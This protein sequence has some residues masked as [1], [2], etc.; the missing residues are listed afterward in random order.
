MHRNNLKTL[1][2]VA[3]LLCRG[4]AYGQEQ[5]GEV[6]GTVVLEDGS[7]I[8]GASVEVSGT[9]LMKNRISVT[10]EDGIFRLPSLPPGNY[11]VT[12]SREGF[13]TVARSD[14]HV[15]LGRTKRLSI[16]LQ[17][18]DSQ[19]EI[20]ATGQIPIVEV[21]N[22]ATTVNVNR[23]TFTTIPQRRNFISVATQQAGVN[24][25]SEFDT[26][27]DD[28][29]GGTAISFDGASASEN[30][31]YIDGMNTTAME[32]GTSGIRVTTDFIEEVQVQSSGYA[33][34]YGG[35]LGGVI[36]VITRSGGNE[37]QGDLIMYYNSNR[38]S[39]GPRETLQFD[40]ED[41]TRA[42]YS[43]YSED[44]WN[45]FEP[46]VTV[47]GYILKDKL[48]FFSSF[49]PR[50]ETRT[51]EGEF[52]NSPEA[53]GEE[54]TAND[55]RYNGSAKI[56]ATLGGNLR[57]SMSGALNHR[58]MVNLLPN[59]DGTSY[60][61]NGNVETWDDWAWSQPGVTTST[62]LDTSMGNRGFLTVSGGY[63]RTNSYFS[64]ERESPSPRIAFQY[65]NFD[66]PGTAKELRRPGGWASTTHDSLLEDRYDIETR[67]TAKADLTYYAGY[68]GEHVLK[69]GFHWNHLGSDKFENASQTEYWRF[70][71]KQPDDG[72]NSYYTA[73]DGT[74][75]ETTYGYVREYGPQGTIAD[76]A[77]DRL[78]FYVQDAW[79]IS[80]KL[81][82]NAGARFERQDM[83]SPS[84]GQIGSAF[85]FGF[86]DTIAPRVGI[87][88]DL[89]GVGDTVI[90]GSFGRYYDDMKVAMAF[91][92]FGGFRSRSAFYDIAT[93]DWT[94]YAS[95]EGYL[96]TGSTGPVLGGRLFE[97]FD[98][99]PGSF[100]LVQ[101][102]QE[103]MGKTEFSIGFQ[104]TLTDDYALAVRFLHHRLVGTIEDMGVVIDGEERFY[105]ANPGSEFANSLYNQSAGQGHMPSGIVTPEPKRDYYSFQLNVDKKF[106][107]HWM[108]GATLTWS[109]LRGNFSGLASSDEHGRRDPMVEE[110]FD[111]WFLPYDSQGHLVYG[112]L[113]TDRPLK[114][115]LRGSTT[116]DNGLSLGTYVQATSGTPVSSELVLNGINGWYPQGRGSDGRTPFLWFIDLFAEYKIE[117]GSRNLNLNVNI[118]NLTNNKIAQ[119]IYNRMNLGSERVL[120]SEIFSG[121]DALAEGAH[122]DP[123]YKMEYE[124]IDAI[125]VRIGIKLTF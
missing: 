86:S 122:D 5:T 99:N 95:E 117:L 19:G 67:L 110:Y 20:V 43:N 21:R 66:V 80:E 59:P 13:K 14:I 74:V 48:W 16:I 35:S 107:K 29:D 78:S 41:P 8:P 58:K 34:E 22:G 27:G 6:I 15:E 109:R 37:F 77:S 42:V 44:S 121:F 56:T 112:P 119:R 60:Y 31:F 116:L 1:F 98:T 108:A 82:L 91:R 83:P 25:E 81:T 85:S 11:T 39:G 55:T 103:P 33:A 90:V 12:I 24:Y 101:P 73:G 115:K 114:L 75:Y 72:A 120:N 89:S 104:K 61:S 10:N 111:T 105:I 40:R 28:R 97:E 17:M 46:G 100:G 45:R 9:R 124:Y 23:E 47:G 30:T 51:R 7:A 87:A 68:R 54:F 79:T 96:L 38:L 4:N 118:T 52:I 92:R 70:Y 3:F 64:G 26:S 113:P 76:L 88:Y 84:N 94:K 53:S 69:T 49:M 50:Y 2:V 62:K 102:D 36:H 57:L 32:D 123:R 93:L 63:F 125:G 18:A 71:W 65:S 106:S